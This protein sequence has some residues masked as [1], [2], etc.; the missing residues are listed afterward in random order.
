MTALKRHTTA[1]TDDLHAQMVALGKAAKHAAAQLA[2][3]DGAHKDRALLAMAAA[4]R[5]DQALILAANAEDMSAARQRD[6]S[7]ALLDRLMLD[8]RRVE[9]IAGGLDDIAHL[10]DS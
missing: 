5:A 2:L 1:A 6:L 7:P 10:P 3:A 9:A 4:L 8:E